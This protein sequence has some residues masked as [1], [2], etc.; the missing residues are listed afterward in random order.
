[1][2]NIVCGFTST[3][4]SMT[5]G[6]STPNDEKSEGR[7]Q[8]KWGRPSACAGHSA[9]LRTAPVET[10]AQTEIPPHHF[11]SRAGIF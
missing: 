6:L 1:M 5:G 7:G 9:P 3:D 10:G 8:R 2:T 11:T 4:L